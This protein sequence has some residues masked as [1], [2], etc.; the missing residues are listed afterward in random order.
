MET[1]F[2]LLSFLAEMGKYLKQ[3]TVFLAKKGMS[4]SSSYQYIYFTCESL[5]Y[6]FY[7]IVL[8]REH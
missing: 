1:G 4:N 2:E 5:N 8:V 3:G 7:H 6:S